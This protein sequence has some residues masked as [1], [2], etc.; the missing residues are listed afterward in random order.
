VRLLFFGSPE[1]AVPSLAALLAS[2]HVVVGVVTQPDRPRGRGQKT[3]P[4]PVAETARAAGVPLLQPERLA[5]PGVAEALDACGA[6]LGVVAAYGK[7]LP[8]WLLALP[9][10]GMV[11]VHASLLPAY[12]GAAPVHRAIMAGERETG[13]TI[14]R[15][16]KALD[17]GP[18]LARSVVPIGVDTTSDE[19]ERELASVGAR[20]LVDV[21]GRLVAGSV[22]EVPQ[23]DTAATY[24]SKITRADSLLDWRLPGQAVHNRIRGLQPWPHASSVFGGARLILHRSSLS[25]TWADGDPGTIADVSPAGVDVVAGDGAIVRLLELQAEGGKRLPAAAFLAGHPLT[26]GQRFEPS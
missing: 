20:L 2:A 8:E 19:L 16:V 18:M 4:G 10:R 5:S 1:F 11:N 13:V 17:A 7:I 12:R 26:V 25:G 15:V 14:M 3:S 9:P 6:D 21:L 24:A 23:D 22:D